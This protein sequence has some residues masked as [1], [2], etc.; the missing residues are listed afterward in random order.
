MNVPVIEECTTGSISYLTKFDSTK[1]RC[2]NKGWRQGNIAL[3]YSCINNVLKREWTVSTSINPSAN[4]PPNIYIFTI[5]GNTI[6][7]LFNLKFDFIR[8]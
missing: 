4:W 5:K 7:Y 6:D 3:I 1:M 2:L 8:I